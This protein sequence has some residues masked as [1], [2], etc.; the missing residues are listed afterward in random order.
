MSITISLVESEFLFFAHRPLPHPPRNDPAYATGGVE[1]TASGPR[2]RR[3]CPPPYASSLPRESIT[4]TSR[5]DTSLLSRIVVSASVRG[6]NWNR[7]RACLEIASG[8]RLQTIWYIWLSCD[9]RSRKFGTTSAQGKWDK[10][11]WFTDRWQSNLS[12]VLISNRLYGNDLVNVCND[13]LKEYNN[14]FSNKIFFFK[15]SRVI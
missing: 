6:F 10:H 12:I 7:R 13:K 8:R 2:R 11:K 9:N 1:T 4:S 5:V 15:L 14:F 3:S